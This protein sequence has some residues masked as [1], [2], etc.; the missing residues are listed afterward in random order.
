MET[1]ELI[2]ILK[3][4]EDSNHQFKVNITNAES[5]AGEM[6]AFS[7]SNGGLIIIG[8]D[9]NGAI[10][11][12]QP[13]ETERINQ[14]ISNAASN[15]VRNPINPVTQSIFINDKIMIIINIP[16]GIDKPYMDN[17][18]V[19]WVKSGADKRRVTSKEEIRRM[20][21][22]S[23]L[24]HS[25]EIPLLN[26]TINDLDLEYFKS[27]YKDVYNTSLEEVQIPLIQLLNNLNVAKNSNLNLTGLLL[28]GKNPQRL[29]PQF[30]VKA[31]YFL[32]NEISGN[33]FRDKEDLDGKIQE[34]FTSSISFIKR[35]LRMK[36]VND[37]FNTQGQL[38]IPEIVF[39]EL[40]ANALMHRNYFIDAPIKLFIFDN[41]IEIISPGTLPNHLTTENIKK[42]VSIIRNPIITSFATKRSLI[43]YSGIGTGIIRSIKIYKD[44]EFY[45]EVELNQ[46]K[47]VIK[48]SS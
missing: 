9:K 31:V 47:V 37:S 2:E 27:F 10:E 32:D 13:S 36:Q 21:Q 43:K 42:G 11:G 34:Q 30:I 28:F 18:G 3:R 26:S 1:L 4:G 40:I 15:N 25:D 20:F 39:E 29:K 12:I 14:L 38:E 45:N 22:S 5:L 7:N 33:S 16:E 48:R 41:R 6:V 35:N 23:D 46:F 19:I 8:A 44:I 17:N 24:I